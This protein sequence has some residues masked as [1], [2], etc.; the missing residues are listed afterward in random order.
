MTMLLSLSNTKLIKNKLRTASFGLL[1]IKTCPS[2]G[3]CK[4]DC[5]ALAGNYVFK[6]V[7]AKQHERFIAS[8]RSDFVV[9]INKE[10][11]QLNVGAVR[12]HDSGDYYSRAYLNKWVEIARSN[13]DVILYSYTK[14]IQFFKSDYNT[15]SID[16]PS[17]MIV[18]FSFGGKKD[19]LIN[20]KTDKHALVFQSLEQLLEYNYNNNSV[21]DDLAYDKDT[22][23]VG[24]IAKS[25]R[26]KTGFGSTFDNIKN[27]IGG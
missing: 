22:L 2:A 18:T 16:L 25:Y 7:K 10:I 5:F 13:P 27:I 12:I 23:R 24:L 8:K 3:N 11:R 19:H 14:S 6:N 21:T 17:N 9:I 20:P 1:A 15:W 26:K 4:T